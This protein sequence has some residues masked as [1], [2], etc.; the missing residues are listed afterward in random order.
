MRTVRNLLRRLG[1]ETQKILS[2]HGG[3][4]NS[5]LTKWRSTRPQFNTSTLTTPGLRR[6]FWGMIRRR[7]V[8]AFCSR[9]VSRRRPGNIL[10]LSPLDLLGL[11]SAALRSSSSCLIFSSCP[12]L[13]TLYASLLTM[14]FFELDRFSSGKF[15]KECV[16]GRVK[17]GVLRFVR[18]RSSIE[19]KA[20]LCQAK[21]R[22][23][24]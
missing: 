7:I 18:V 17:F 8:N 4:D 11:F 6:E 24:A 10:T 2:A 22:G 16:V 23:T 20:R 15:R 14:A 21:I 3:P 5:L 1:Q 9:E 12:Y 19:T 13:L